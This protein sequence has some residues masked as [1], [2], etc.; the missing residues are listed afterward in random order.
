MWETGKQK[1]SQNAIGVHCE[2]WG[3]LLGW[4]EGQTDGSSYR[5]LY[6]KKQ[7]LVKQ[8]EETI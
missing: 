3:P 1:T 2:R 8:E 5:L 7:V 6:A 4:N